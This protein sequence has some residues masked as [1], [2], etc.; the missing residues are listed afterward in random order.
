LY[1]GAFS[2]LAGVKQAAIESRCSDRLTALG[3]AALRT[4][5]EDESFVFRVFVALVLAIA[6]KP[7][8]SKEWLSLKKIGKSI[9]GKGCRWN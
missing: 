5:R 7:A 4:K 2:A 8:E 3:G 6:G 1:S 9:P